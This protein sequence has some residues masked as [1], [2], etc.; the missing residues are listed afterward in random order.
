MVITGQVR[1]LKIIIV[2]A[3]SSPE[4]KEMAKKHGADQFLEKP[5]NITNL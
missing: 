3:F 1:P 5:I 2:T 4:D